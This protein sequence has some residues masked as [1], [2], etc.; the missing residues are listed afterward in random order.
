MIDLITGD[1]LYGFQIVHD[2]DSE[3]PTGPDFHLIVYTLQGDSKS[4]FVPKARVTGDQLAE[5]LHARGLMP[6]EG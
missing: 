6:P 1:N 5:A 2:P 3:D 4:T